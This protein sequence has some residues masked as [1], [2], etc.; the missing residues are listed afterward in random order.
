MVEVGAGG[1]GE[2]VSVW[3]STEL[4]TVGLLAGGGGEMSSVCVSMST[5]GEG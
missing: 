2:T 1:G 5:I 3:V 4:P